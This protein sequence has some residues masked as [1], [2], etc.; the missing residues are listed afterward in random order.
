M[1]DLSR[2]VEPKSDQMNADDLIAG[3][4]TITVTHVT[5]S[6]TPEQ[7]V[8]VHFEGCNGKPWKPCK[9]MRRVLIAAWG[10]DAALF[11]GRSL[12]LYNDPEVTF[13]G[14][15]T[16]GIRISHMTGL[17]KVL[18]IALTATKAKRAMFTVQP[19]QIT[20]PAPQ[21]TEAD[22]QA[23]AR[24]AAAQGKAAFTA[25]WNSAEGKQCRAMV[26]PIMAE[27]KQTAASAAEILPPQTDDEPPAQD[28]EPI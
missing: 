7:P 4:R 2:T 24:A 21:I 15:K 25:W 3:P 6:E 17:D 5:A 12:T 9:S 14:M 27:L 8:S 18:K 26:Q 1:V 23:A 28:E 22:A 13:G 11:A 10:A 20:P 16:G 19:L